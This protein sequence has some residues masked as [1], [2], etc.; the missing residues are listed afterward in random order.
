[1]FVVYLTLKVD[2]EFKKRKNQETIDLKQK[3]ITE[4]PQSIGYLKCKELLLADN[5]INTLPDDIGKLPNLTMLDLANNR[6]NG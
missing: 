2:K 5:E 1:L 6:V 4:L 3:G